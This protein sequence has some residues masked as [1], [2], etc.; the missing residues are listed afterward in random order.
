MILNAHESDR[1]YPKEMERTAPLREHEAQ[2]R[3]LPAQ[4]PQAS[5]NILAME[6]PKIPE[7]PYSER[8]REDAIAMQ[9]LN[10]DRRDYFVNLFKREEDLT[11]NRANLLS[12]ENRIDNKPDKK[13]N[14][15]KKEKEVFP[16]GSPGYI[17]EETD[18]T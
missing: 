1:I 15:K 14:E 2:T 11:A 8:E 3:Q 5:Q 9:N 12:R 4:Y 10:D 7:S 18:K 17:K 6:K 16:A 13:S